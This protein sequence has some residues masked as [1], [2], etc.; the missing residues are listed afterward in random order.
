[1]HYYLEVNDLTHEEVSVF[2]FR[3]SPLYFIF[4]W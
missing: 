3:I 1:M 4:V 2:S